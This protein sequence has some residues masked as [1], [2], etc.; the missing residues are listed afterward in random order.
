M[1]N[2][3]IEEQNNEELNLSSPFKILLDNEFVKI[4]VPSF[5]IHPNSPSIK[6]KVIITN[7]ILNDAAKPYSNKFYIRQKQQSGTPVIELCW[8]LDGK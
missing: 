4:Q 2:W 8:N 6:Y 3:K 5:E 7:K 1:S